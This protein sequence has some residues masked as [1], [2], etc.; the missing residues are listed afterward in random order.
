M[1]IA[2]SSLSTAEAGAVNLGYSN[3]S[4][5]GVNRRDEHFQLPT[6][7]QRVARDRV[8]PR[9]R[10]QVASLVT[11]IARTA[12]HPVPR[13]VYPVIPFSW[14]TLIRMI[15]WRPSNLYVS[16]E[17]VPIP[18]SNPDSSIAPPGF[19]LG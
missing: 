10:R 1:A 15:Q 12:V 4:E 19:V 18:L 17:L 2:S 9:T 7:R 13:P 5:K 6:L 8:S 16:P 14:K 11:M 3:G